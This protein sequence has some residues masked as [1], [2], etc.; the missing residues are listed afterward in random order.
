MKSDFAKAPAYLELQPLRVPAGWTIGWNNLY[1]TSKVEE[2]DFGGSSVFYAFNE[3]RRFSIDVEFRPEFDP[4]GRFELTVMYQ[5]WPRTERGRRRTDLPF[6]FDSNAEL[7]H[8]HETALYGELV[9]ELENWIARCT[10]AVR[11]GH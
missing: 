8:A 9:D 6:Q 11:E 2:G 10:T 7:V 3:G 5:P 4:T 1:T